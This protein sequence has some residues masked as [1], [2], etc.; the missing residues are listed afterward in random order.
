[1]AMTRT[2]SALGVF[3]LAVLCAGCFGSATGHRPPAVRR[4]VERFELSYLPGYGIGEP[5]I[6]PIRISHL[7]CPGGPRAACAAVK[8]ALAHPARVCASTVGTPPEVGISGTLHGR[9]VS[10]LIDPVCGRSP[11]LRHAIDTLAAFASAKA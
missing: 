6:R 8:Y 11:R 5:P 10:D 2:P 1:M 3:A 7:S 9:T 4:P